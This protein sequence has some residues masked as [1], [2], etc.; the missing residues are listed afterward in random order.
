MVIAARWHV[1][2]DVVGH[3]GMLVCVL[4]AVEILEIVGEARQIVEKLIKR[5]SRL[6]NL[7]QDVSPGLTSLWCVRL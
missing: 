5:V 2:V 6:M 1:S 3:T 7:L 4:S